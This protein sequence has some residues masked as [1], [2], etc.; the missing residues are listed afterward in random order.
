MGLCCVVHTNI[1]QKPFCSDKT[2]NRREVD[3]GQ[4][5]VLD[6]VNPYLRSW[7]ELFFTFI[8]AKELIPKEFTVNVNNRHEKRCSIFNFVDG[9]SQVSPIYRKLKQL[10]NYQRRSTIQKRL[11]KMRRNSR[12][13][14]TNKG[15]FILYFPN[16]LSGIISITCT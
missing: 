4:R 2:N 13:Y 1:L 9:M 10:F 5:V 12:S 3:R 6:I 7:R 8:L 14:N 11:I 15:A 16:F